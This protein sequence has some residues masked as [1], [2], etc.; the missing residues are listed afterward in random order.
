MRE[1]STN[2]KGVP[3]SAIT[4]YT[5]PARFWEDHVDRGCRCAESCPDKAEHETESTYGETV[6]RKYRVALT[7]LDAAELLSDARFYSDAVRMMGPDYFGV[8]SSARATVKV[9]QR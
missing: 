1:Q 8:Q 5:L 9:L 7:D 2:P 6:G 4:T 3:M